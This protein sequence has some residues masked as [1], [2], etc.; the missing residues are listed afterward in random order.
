MNMT[1]MAYA[2]TKSLEILKS[3]FLKV[4]DF[5]QGNILKALKFYRDGHNRLQ[6]V[7]NKSPNFIK[8][9]LQF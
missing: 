1:F 4:S 3:T 9:L 7:Q 2:V 6:L 5:D 8:N